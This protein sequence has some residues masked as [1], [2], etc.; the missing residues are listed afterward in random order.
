MFPHWLYEITFYSH[1]VVIMPAIITILPASLWKVAQTFV[2]GLNIRSTI[3][4]NFF[5]YDPSRPITLNIYVF[6]IIFI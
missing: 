3:I 1:S 6:T 5:F 4:R 2:L